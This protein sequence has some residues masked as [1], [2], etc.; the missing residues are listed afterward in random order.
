MSDKKNVATLDIWGR[1]PPMSAVPL[2]A[3]MLPPMLV[4]ADEDAAAEAR[5]QLREYD[6]RTMPIADAT[7]FTGR[8][9]TVLPA[10]GPAGRTA[11][12]AAYSA[13]VAAVAKQVRLV[14]AAALPEL[15]DL[16]QVVRD[17]Q[18]FADPAELAR[19]A[20]LPDAAW[21]S[22]RIPCSKRIGIPVG[23]LKKLRD[24]YRREREEREEAAKDAASA[25]PP[26]VPAALPVDGVAL[27][28][29]FA[30]LIARYVSARP[31]ERD[32]LTLWPLVVHCLEAF[33]VAP[34]I[35]AT[36]EEENEGKTT[37]L[38]ILEPVVPR[39]DLNDEITAAAARRL[40]DAITRDET[41]PPTL[42][43]DEQDQVND[44]LRKIINACHKRGKKSL[45]TVGRKAKSFTLFA[46]VALGMIGDPPR[47]IAS[48]GI[49]IKMRRALLEE[50]LADWVT[51]KSDAATIIRLADIAARMARWALDHVP[52]LRVAPRPVLSSLAN[53]NRNN[54]HP[55]VAV[56]EA[57]GGTWPE[58]ARRAAVWFEARRGG[59]S[60]A[61]TLACDIRDVLPEL[62]QVFLASD[63]T[64]PFVSA[65][66]LFEALMERNDDYHV[67]TPAL[68]RHSLGRRL[69][70]FEVPTMVAKVKRKPCRVFL[71]Q[72]LQEFA[73]RYAPRKEG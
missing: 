72:G 29:D 55:F 19:I 46:P 22:E 40:I 13:I 27:L 44:Q 48:R 37:V 57:V 12:L 20:Q 63:R 1:N 66:V 23:D 47:T 35:L 21:Q 52:S 51:E 70:R 31:E 61:G 58:R 64:K 30:D 9:V 41:A 10:P 56:A 28:D 5:S 43:F 3:P 62:P 16:R 6:I 53:R 60:F 49:R 38:E 18:G 2:S 11:A 32:A 14:D 54:W 7:E 24:A 15:Y 67:M 36:S 25:P 45:I 42:L 71:F 65:Q 4:V 34:Q 17:A 50:G 33:N 73:A 68:T 26:I 69:G 39:P 59:D 8:Y